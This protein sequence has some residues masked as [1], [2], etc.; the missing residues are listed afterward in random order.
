MSK[1]LFSLDRRAVLASGASA[2]VL[3]A[4]SSIIGPPD[5]APLYVLDP[6]N[7]P[8][9]R[10][11]PVHWQLT[12]VL[13][14]TS[15]SLDTTRISLLLPAGQ[16]DYYANANWQDRLPFLVQGSLVEAFEATGRMTRVGR[17]T[18][19]LKSD[20]LMITDIRDFQA[21]YAV[22]DTPPKVEVR[23]VAKLLNART[24]T[25]VQS[26]DAQSAIQ[27]DQNSIASV[28]TAM[29][30]ALAN[31]QSQIVEWA[32]RAPPPERS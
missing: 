1:K 2:V 18:E 20:Y 29:N 3:S 22:A 13:P 26:I 10:M 28:V 7:P 5:A 25:I 30:L 17:E 8:A 9:G 27:V 19:G 11:P 31:V 21:R 16:M 4:C 14:E 12:V 15:D 24:R 23:I 32:L 6:A